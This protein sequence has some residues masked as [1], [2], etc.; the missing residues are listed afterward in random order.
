MNIIDFLAGGGGGAGDFKKFT[1]KKKSTT[2]TTGNLLELKKR[3]SDK[4][5]PFEYGAER[6]IYISIY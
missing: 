5:I 6:I 1:L 4:Y 2:I 3:G